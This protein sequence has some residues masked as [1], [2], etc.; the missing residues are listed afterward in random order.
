MGRRIGRGPASWYGR[1]LDHPPPVLEN[2][3]AAAAVRSGL[4]RLLESDGRRF[5]R[6]FLAGWPLI[7]SR[8]ERPFF[9]R[10]GEAGL[11]GR[12][13]PAIH[14]PRVRLFPF[15]ERLVA[16][17]L[18]GRRSADQV[19][20]LMFEQA[21]LVRNMDVRLGDEVLEL[22]VGSGANALVAADAAARVTGV[23]RS[24]R[25]LAFARFNA[26]LNGRAGEIELLEGSLFGP[27]A[28][29]RFDLVLVNPPFEPVPPGG[30][31]Y[32]HSDGGEDGLDVVREILAAAPEHLKPGGR[33]EMITW[34]PG[35]ARGP[36]LIRLLL[37]AF[38]D[39]RV[40]VDLLGDEPIE[41]L[42]ARFRKSAGYAA[43]RE[44]LL[45]RGLD[46]VYLVF[47]R[48]TPGGEGRRIE[49]REPTAEIEACHAVA[50]GWAH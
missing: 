35:S 17:D 14:D 25:A 11:V 33:L 42:L 40:R 37:D 26:A 6:L 24:P 12:L 50:D 4:A 48:V 29:R 47:A 32:L 31:W 46:R 34:S 7:V 2:P 44:G 45:A 36:E 20:S 19:F 49:V 9:A 39:R 3:A 13:A 5:R 10:L 15:A 1:F 30:G 23:D 22:C 16:T 18:L 21:Y 28:E 43:W 27:V 41:P 8:R 38:P